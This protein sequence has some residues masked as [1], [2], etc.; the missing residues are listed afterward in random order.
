MTVATAGCLLSGLGL[1]FEG[2]CSKLHDEMFIL[3]VARPHGDHQRF[4]S[5]EQQLQPVMISKLWTRG[6]LIF[7]LRQGRVTIFKQVWFDW[8]V[9]LSSASSTPYSTVH[10]CQ[11]N[12]TLCTDHDA[13]HPG[14]VL[15]AQDVHV[16]TRL[17]LNLTGLCSKVTR[18]LLNLV[19]CTDQLLQLTSKACTI[20][21]LRTESPWPYLPLH[22]LW[23]HVN[24]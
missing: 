21:L 16:F 13:V 18:H 15:C 17:L 24:C 2:V 22:I 11:L 23:Y 19:H 3:T 6:G 8:S 4:C 20:L 7:G 10:G 1:V 14:S 9:D 12:L 5:Y